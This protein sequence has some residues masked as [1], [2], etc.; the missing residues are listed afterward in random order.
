MNLEAA[1]RLYGTPRLVC[2]GVD[3]LME[4]V[5]SHG[6]DILL[7]YILH[8]DQAALARTE[9]VVLQSAELDK[10]VFVEHNFVYSFSSTVIPFGNPS[11]LIVTL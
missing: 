6:I 5:A 9:Y 4:N 10:G 3:F 11:R 1:H 2:V 7:P 8:V